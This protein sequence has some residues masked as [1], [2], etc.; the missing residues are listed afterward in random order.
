MNFTN[1]TQSQRVQKAF[2]A[3]SGNLEMKEIKIQ[4]SENRDV[5][6]FLTNLQPAYSVTKKSSSLQFS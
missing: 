3:R 6:D 1:Q 5:T 4:S 2:A